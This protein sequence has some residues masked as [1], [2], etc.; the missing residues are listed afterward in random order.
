MMYNNNKRKLEHF[1][2]NLSPQS[3]NT[4]VDTTTIL[5][6]S[7][8]QTITTNTNDKNNLNVV[9]KNEEVEQTKNMKKIEMEM[10]SEGK[11][12]NDNNQKIIMKKLKTNNNKESEIVINGNYHRLSSPSLSENTDEHSSRVKNDDHSSSSISIS[13]DNPIVQSTKADF[14]LQQQ[15]SEFAFV[16]S[17][18]EQQQQQQQQQHHCNSANL[19]NRSS[20]LSSSSSSSASS[21]SS[22]PSPSNGNN[23]SNNNSPNPNNNNSN[24]NNNPVKVTNVYRGLYPIKDVKK[25]FKKKTVNNQKLYICQW[26]GCSFQTWKY[27]QHISRHIYLKHIGIKELRCHVTQCEKVFKRPESLVQH[28]KNHICGFGIDPVRMKDPNNTCGVKNIKRHFNKIMDNDIHVFMCQF[29]RCKFVTNNSG[30]IRRH[31]HNQHICPHSSSAAAATAAA[32][33]AATNNNNNNNNNNTVTALSS[34]SSTTSSSNSFTIDINN[35][36]YNYI[37]KNGS[38]SAA[39]IIQQPHLSKQQIK[40]TSTDFFF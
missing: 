22:S 26:P 29:E 8:Q 25:Y 4:S 35:Y 5:Q 24:N 23:N 3:S 20:P 32:A 34:G 15:H 9:E 37:G 27:S 1:I 16:Q 14:E 38:S 11:D 21:S 30:S 36:N 12:N 39:E 18:F 31:V 28:V 19:N 40:R 17:F 33:A 7:E 13:L 2:A 10:V 6:S